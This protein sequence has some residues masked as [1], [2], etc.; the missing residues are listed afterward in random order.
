MKTCKSENGGQCLFSTALLW[1]M[2]NT[3]K[4]ELESCPD[5]EFIF[6]HKWS[7]SNTT[8]IHDCLGF[9]AADIPETYRKI[10]C[11]NAL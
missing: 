8:L 10:R 1:N 2:G 9:N 7:D 6:S 5:K 3:T 4:S 11:M